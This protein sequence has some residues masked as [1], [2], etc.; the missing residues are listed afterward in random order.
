MEIGA[1]LSPCKITVFAIGRSPLL[2]VC[3]QKL[4]C[5]AW[6]VDRIG[7]ATDLL[8]CRC[9]CNGIRAFFKSTIS[10]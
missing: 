8:L 9:S 7:L 5:G 2:S 6:L 3:D 10:I 1:I 4:L